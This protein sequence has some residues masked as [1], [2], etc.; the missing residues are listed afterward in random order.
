MADALTIGH[1]PKFDGINFLG[2][3]F[4]IRTS[5]IGQGI[6]DVVNGTRKKPVV[7]AQNGAAQEDLLK[8][9][10][11]DDAKAMSFISRALEYKHLEPLLTCESSKAMWDKLARIHAQNSESN[12]LLLMEKFHKYQ[13]GPTDSVVQHVAK[14]QNMAAQ[15]TDLGENMSDNQIMVKILAGL[16]SK[17]SN[18]QTAWDSVEPGRQTVENLQERLIKE[19]GRLDA[20]ADETTALAAIRNTRE[21][22]GRSKNK[23][24]S[25]SNEEKKARQEKKKKS[26]KC[27]ECEEKGHYASE[28]LT[29]KQ[30]KDGH[31]KSESSGCAFVAEKSE[32]NDRES[33]RYSGPPT[34]VKKRWLSLDKK[35]VWYTDSGASRVP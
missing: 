8:V 26:V 14:V 10:I 23:E 34:D 7:P 27:F 13:M 33:S 5:L 9:W 25:K 22:A 2:W 35:E 24:D 31:D 21:K 32:R 28:C 20:E 19:E 17:F 18:L 15:L 30:K 11:K 4:Q 1:V 16:T 3:K 12:K 29:R 6:F